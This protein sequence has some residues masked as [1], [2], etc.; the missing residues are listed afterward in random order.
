M[1]TLVKYRKMIQFNRKIMYLKNE[2]TYPPP[3]APPMPPMPRKKEK[4]ERRKENK[5]T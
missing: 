2:E 4:E 1:K 5:G 3:P